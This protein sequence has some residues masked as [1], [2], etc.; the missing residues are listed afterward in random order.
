MA[1]WIVKCQLDSHF[2]ST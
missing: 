2:R 1:T